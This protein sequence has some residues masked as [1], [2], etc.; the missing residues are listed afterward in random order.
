MYTDSVH[1]LPEDN[2]PASRPA[3]RL[4]R[5]PG[6]RIWAWVLLAAVMIAGLAATYRIFVLSSQGQ[7]VDHAALSS[8]EVRLQSL[9]A[10]S[11]GLLADL[12]IVVA[13]IAAVGFLVLTLWRRRWAA[14]L[15]VALT[16]A[17]A[18]FTTQVLKIL[19]DRP[20][21]ANG[22]PYYTGNS[23]PS[24]HVTFAT[25]TFAAVFL[26][27]APRWRSTVGLVGMIFSATVGV[28]TFL[29]GW[30]RPADIVAAY[31]V[32]GLWTLIG[33]FIIYRVSADYNVISA[34]S[35]AKHA[36]LSEILLWLLAVIGIG[37]AVAILLLT[38]G[39][40]DLPT[41]FEQVTPSLRWFTFG[42]MLIVGAA[43]L[44]CAL[45]TSFFR[46]EAGRQAAGDHREAPR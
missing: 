38:G 17:A 6:S 19:L 8:A 33:G 35:R 44:V 39:L 31:L 24:G 45:L 40:G 7:L 27:V 10:A 46:W 42:A 37:G 20:E 41:H 16:F 9:H 15:I 14:S 43:S 36:S 5:A 29:D 12:P 13:A 4:V 23:L 28:A 32:V 22:V 34:R 25:A 26:L 30:H 2:L 1:H 18:N 3:R 11:V 21:L